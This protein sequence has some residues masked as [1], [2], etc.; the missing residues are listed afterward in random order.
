MFALVLENNPVLEHLDLR[1]GNNAAMTFFRLNNTPNLTCINAEATISQ[2]MTDSGKSFS[3]DC[4]DFVDIV[5]AN[6]E[7]AL[8]DLGI[9]S[10]GAVNSSILRSDA[11]AVTYLNLNNPLFDNSNFANQEIVNVTGKIADLTG[12]DAFIN[13]INLQAAYGVLTS[14]DLTQ[15]TKLEELFLNDNQL[16]QVDISILPNLK[17]FGIMRNPITGTV[18]VSHNAALEEI[19][20]HNTGISEIDLSANTNLW[21]LFIQGN[22]ITSL[23]LSNNPLTRLYVSDNL[24]LEHLDLRNDNNVNLSFIR[25]QNTPNLNCIN[26]DAIISQAM[27]DS[28]K[29]F[30]TDCGDFVDIPDPNFEQALIDSGIDSDGLVDGK[31]LRS[32]AE[33]VTELNVTNPKFAS[34]QRYANQEIV[35]VNEKIQ[36]LTG[37]EA[38]VNITK[39]SA[40]AN[41]LTQID[42]SQNTQLTTLELVNNQIASIDVSNN[43]DLEILWLETN[44]LSQID[45]TNNPN[46]LNIALGYN[47]LTEI[48]VTQNTKLWALTIE[49][50]DLTTVDVSQNTVIAQIWVAEN[51]NLTQMDFSRN[52]EMYGLGIYN[53]AIRTL[54]LSNNP[55]TRLYIGNN[56]LLEHLDLRNGNNQS[57]NQ[58]WVANTPNLTCI[59][60]D[61]TI[62]QVMQDSAK[63]FSQD[64]GDFIY[65]PDPNFEQALI[66]LGIDSD[67]VVNTSILRKDVENITSLNL[68]FPKL[69]NG[70]DNSFADPRLSITEKIVDLTGIEAFINLTNLQVGY[71]ALTQVD[72]SA[73]TK[74]EELF[75]NDNQL[76]AVDISML[77]NLKR[78]GIMRNQMTSGIDVTNNPLLEE[79]FVHSTGIDQIDL[80]LNPLLWNL[81]IA[82]N[83]LTQLDL[84]NNSELIRLSCQHNSL[85]QLDI[86]NLSVIDRVDAQFN[87]NFVL[88]TGA[89]GNPSLK[90]LNLSGTGMTNFNGATY[91]NLEWLLLN[92]NALTNFNANNNL[93]LQNLFLNDN[94]ISKLNLSSATQLVQLQVKN[95]V[96]EELDLRNGNNIQLQ[97]LSATG[98]FLTC[99]SVD[100]PTDS[101][102]PYS[103]WELDLGVTLNL[104]CKQAPEVVLIPDS[105]FEQVLIDSGFDTNGLSGNILLTDAEAITVLN[106]SGKN[107]ADATGIEA[108]VNLTDVDFSNN[109]LSEIDLSQ[110]VSLANL[111]VSGNNLSDLFISNGKK[112]IS[113][114]ASGN[115]L[116]QINYTDLTNLEIMDIAGNNFESLNFSGLK[117][118]TY[119]DV[120]DNDLT[121]LDLRNGNNSAITFMNATGNPSLVCAGVDDSSNIPGGWNI[122]STTSYTNTGDC[123]APV[124]NTRNIT[125]SL[126]RYGEAVIDPLDV[127]GGSNDAVTGQKDLLYELDNST[128][129]C[130]NLG[131]NQVMLLVTDASGNTGTGTATVN[132]IDE[133]A[134]AASSLR[135]YQ[136][137]LAGA[138]SVDLDPLEINDGSSDNC[139]DLEFTLDQSSFSF[140][141]DYTV[142]LT[143]TDASGNSATSTTDVQVVDSSSNPTSLKFQRNL[144]ATVYPNPFSDK[145]RIAFSKTIDLNNVEVQL[146]S[147]SQS[148]TGVQFEVDGNEIVST[149]ADI[150][151]IATYSLMIT[152]NGETQSAIVIKE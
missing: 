93:V 144:V 11:E 141:G 79:L 89:A 106:V 119:I 121:N 58:F 51:P 67:G 88:T 4:G 152:V 23:D 113:L 99:I 80:S 70:D 100:Y 142:T 84:S 69:S 72:L 15:N 146:Y 16:T 52:T 3:E 128:F 96:L 94:S 114:E 127:D 54:D 105:N 63:N 137:D 5:D 112:I 17:R 60:A 32:D 22:N 109:F 26:A 50:N 55:I 43:P 97:R 7:Q 125:I 13:L 59:N 18:D 133:I 91:P 25:I 135:S 117:T 20:V 10:D 95:N 12:I 62:S 116:N 101:T 48:D 122:D 136:L 83:N 8:I 108:F 21:N 19:F 131:E 129:S 138:S 28:G 92:N 24:L 74:L 37:L 111:N 139:N 1:N 35:N 87:P 148:I 47:N 151:S 29:S 110:N 77:P 31:I 39:L 90:S 124:V 102:M 61:S 120:S 49:G 130:A 42:V 149:N 56:P 38:F 147:M 73:N 46:L 14:V 6:F 107:I 30:S 126:D 41:A 98:N 150:L 27:I 103:Q 123:E 71:A 115:Q 33:A 40:W 65:I 68:N 34:D 104:N 36:D 86:S 64:C 85:S 53:T 78:F 132:V 118:L 76:N 140:P 81:F 45:V 82:D 134:P 2:A 57:L 44:N 143:V 145:I 75:L 66:D 9:D